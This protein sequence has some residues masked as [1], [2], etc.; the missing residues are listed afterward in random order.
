MKHA[1]ELTYTPDLN[2]NV[3]EGVMNLFGCGPENIK[4]FIDG[5]IIS[6]IYDNVRRDRNLVVRYLGN[7]YFMTVKDLVKDKTVKFVCYREGEL[8]YKTEDGFEFTVPTSDT[9]TGTFMAEDKAILYMRWIRKQWEA[10]EEWKRQK[11]AA[12]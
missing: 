10:E 7:D 11:D 2:E 9:G 8:T 1:L 4:R 12:K 5:C 3:P 6:K